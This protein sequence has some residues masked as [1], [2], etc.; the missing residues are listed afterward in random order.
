MDLAVFLKTLTR[1]QRELAE[2]LGSETT[3][4]ISRRTGVP[5]STIYDRVSQIRK[6]AEDAGLA[7]Y[8][9]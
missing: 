9:S 2:S 1:E 7:K 5:R 6:L 8:L 3:L 4:D